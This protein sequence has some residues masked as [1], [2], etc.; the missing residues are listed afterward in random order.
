MITLIM[1]VASPHNTRD[2]AVVAATAI[3]KHKAHID[4]GD[5]SSRIRTT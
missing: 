2:R 4:G 5:S 3:S 1:R